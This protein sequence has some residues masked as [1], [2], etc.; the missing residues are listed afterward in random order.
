M[1]PFRSLSLL[2]V[3]TMLLSLLIAVASSAVAQPAEKILHT[4]TAPD[5]AQPIGDLVADAAGNLYGVTEQGGNT[6]AACSLASC[7]TVFKLSKNSGG[8]WALSTIYAFHGGSD[9]AYPVG[10]LTFDKAGN[11]YGTT[12]QGGSSPGSAGFGIVFELSPTS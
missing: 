4:F 5:G 3:G 10:G 2:S 7:G 9:G 12:Y 6:L 8:S 11:L 1:R